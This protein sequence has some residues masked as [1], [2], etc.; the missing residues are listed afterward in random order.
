MESK[1]SL[2]KG[3]HNDNDNDDDNDDD[4][5]NN[6]FENELMLYPPYIF[7]CTNINQTPFVPRRPYR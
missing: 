4:N 1:Q 3:T 5:D 6:T 2:K 7:V